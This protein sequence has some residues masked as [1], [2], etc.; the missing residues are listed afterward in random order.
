[1]LAVVLDHAFR[2]PSGGF[3]G[4]DVFFVISGFV[5]T[6][7]LLAERARTGRIRLRAFAV[8]RI[9]RLAPAS[10]LVLLVTTTAA[11][12][13]LPA[14]RFGAVA[15]DAV[16]SALAVQN[17]RLAA[18]G[19]DYFAATAAASPFQHFWS[20]GV[21]EQFYL[22]LPVLMVLVLGRGAGAGRT[23]LA[24]AVVGTLALC[25]L[26]WAFVA[27]SLDPTP[28]Y[29]ST[30]TRAWELG[31]GVVVA[32]VVR[33]AGGRAVRPV[34]AESMVLVGLAAIVGAVVLGRESTGV[35]APL[36]LV[37]TIGTALVLLA[38][39]GAGRQTWA[40]APLRWR[41]LVGLGTVSYSLYLWHWP[42][43]VLLPLFTSVPMPAIVAF[44]LLAAIAS[45][46]TVETAFRH[47]GLLSTLRE[48]RLRLQ[49]G[50]LTVLTVLTLITVSGTAERLKPLP[51]VPAA[52]ATE[53]GPADDDASPALRARADVVA[54]GLAARDW[55][56]ALT[57]SAEAISSADYAD[58]LTTT[59]EWASTIGC[60]R[61]GADWRAEGCTWGPEA[62]PGTDIVLTGDS[63]GAFSAPGWRAL[64][65]DP[66]ADV[67]VR[68][69]AQIG[70]PF[71][72]TALRSDSATCATHNAEVLA[73]LERTT[74]DVL[75]VTNR[76]WDENDPS[77]E[78]IDQDAY[79]HGVRE[80]IAAA[81][82]HVGR[83]IVVPATPPGYAPTSCT[84]G[85][86]GP[87]D[88]RA[89]DGIARSQMRSLES[90]L[91]GVQGT[92]VLDTTPL[93]CA[94][95]SCPLLIGD[96]LTRF[97]P[98]H[99]T[100]EA[101]QASAPALLDLLRQHDV[102]PGVRRSTP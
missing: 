78:S 90:V 11:W 72:T 26:A 38:G 2:W 49:L 96:V 61:L 93:W 63:T 73:E 36:A 56:A 12:V 5:I 54:A 1:V 7:G 71:S 21:E 75:V 92:E 35:P 14:T 40:A 51:A 68:N 82:G 87:Q 99:V 42:F 86:K 55:P 53:A 48:N 79:Q 17:W 29:F 22:V 77:L 58:S 97:D 28:A 27:V 66:E 52:A 44:S 95:G 59:S 88:C 65:E 20:L 81:Q 83:V 67:R 70:C 13:L 102:L 74:P 16:W 23:R 60:S 43:I 64:A 15:T 46:A 4:V 39:S 37:P 3:L 30:A 100:P 94:Y 32:L 101:S 33:R 80:M 62:E 10:L 19:T 45:H 98:V 76:F 57:P 9:R 31:L 18:Q 84:A 41:P 91:N 25:S 89:G 8:R 50:G 6:V 85:T 34:L 69:A 47:R 24:T